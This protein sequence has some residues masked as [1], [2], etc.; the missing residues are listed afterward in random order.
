MKFGFKISPFWII[1]PFQG[2]PSIQWCCQI[3]VIFKI[4]YQWHHSIM[5]GLRIVYKCF[6]D[7]RWNLVSTFHL[8][9]LLCLFKDFDPYND[10]E[11]F[12][13]IQWGLSFLEPLFT[14]RWWHITRM[15]VHPLRAVSLGAIVDPKVT[16]VLPF[17]FH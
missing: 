4:S 13:S 14:Q 6:Q 16:L 9:E 17:T 12:I 15:M 11:K 2:F 8:F 5:Q 3:Y 10:A 1:L 7:I